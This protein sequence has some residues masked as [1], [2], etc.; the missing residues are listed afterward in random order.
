MLSP[1]E[2]AKQT[3]AHKAINK[4]VE[5][6][7]VLGI[8]SGSTIVYAVERLAERVAKEN[9]EVVCIPTSFQ[10]KQLI[11]KHGL[12][13]GSLDTHPILDVCIDG[14]DEVDANLNI[15]KGGGAC[16]L[17]EKIIASCANGLVIIA[18][19]TKNSTK[20]GDQYKKGIPIEVV[21]MSYVPVRNKIRNTFGGEV[22][23]RMAVA[24][25]G[26]VITDNGN[27]ILDWVNFKQ[28]DDWK[29]VNTAIRMIPG[30]VETGL[31]LQMAKI[32]YFGQADGTIKEQTA[33]DGH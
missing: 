2:A 4:H 7:F 13:L 19:Y 22:N 3:A 33:K 8:G 10:A 24:K 9:L 18:D 28:L 32:V 14:A 15:I 25:A 29:E 5:N 20:L 30:V 26:P 16:L 6:N 17:E 1:L 21:P 23:L 12:K 27:F 31:F 11:V